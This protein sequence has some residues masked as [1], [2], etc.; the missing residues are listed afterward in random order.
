LVG[1]VTEIYIYTLVKCPCV[2][3][4]HKLFMHNDYIKTSNILWTTIL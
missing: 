4:A 3:T 1:L 2:A